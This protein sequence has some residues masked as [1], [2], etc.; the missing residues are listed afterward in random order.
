MAVHSVELEDLATEGTSSR[1]IL[2]RNLDVIKN[3]KVKLEIFLGEAELTVGE[4]FDLNEDSVVKLDR[5]VTA[6]VDIVLDGKVVARGSLVVV[7][8]NFG[9]RIT[10][11]RR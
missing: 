3:V 5:D 2:D 11:I 10:Q 1:P 9:V 7:D 8:D 6:P 4:L